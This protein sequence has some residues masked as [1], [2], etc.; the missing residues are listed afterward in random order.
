M[1]HDQLCE[2]VRRIADEAGADHAAVA[3]YDYQTRRGWDCDG[4]RWF[5]AASTIKVPFLLGVFGEI[6]A[7]RLARDSRL[8]V[9]NRFLS[10]A[11]GSPY[12]VDAARDAN[13]VVPRHLGRTMKVDALC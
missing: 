4:D 6:H 9:R 10:V 13:T 11:D 12:R 7:T 8:H 5:H 3:C 2:R 1:S